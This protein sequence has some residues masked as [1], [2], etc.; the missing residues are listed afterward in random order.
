MSAVPAPGLFEVN[1]IPTTW[2]E[3]SLSERRPGDRIN[4]E[5]DVLARYVEA[6]LPPAA[7]PRPVT[8]ELLRAAGFAGGPEA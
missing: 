1:V 6:L 8:M 3:T 7:A 5:T 4:L 2:R